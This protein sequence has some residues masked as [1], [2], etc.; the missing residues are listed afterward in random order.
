MNAE[1]A[2]HG[3]LT[4]PSDDAPGLTNNPKSCRQSTV[5]RIAHKRDRHDRSLARSMIEARIR[6][7]ASGRS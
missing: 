2:M 4:E 7:L 5:L 3:H 6:G 1:R